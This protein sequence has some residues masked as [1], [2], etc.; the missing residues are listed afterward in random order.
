MGELYCIGNMEEDAVSSI[1]FTPQA[2]D[3]KTRY[4]IAFSA[5]M[6]SKRV[7]CAISYQALRNHFDADYD[8]PMP[9]FITHRQRIEQLAAA[10]IRQ[11]RFE[12]DGTILIRSHDIAP[13]T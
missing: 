2:T 12:S 6:G 8:N 7:E 5:L 11:D 4:V 13:G 9:A 1:Q 10:F 3:D